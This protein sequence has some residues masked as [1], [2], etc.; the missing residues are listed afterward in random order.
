MPDARQKGFKEKVIEFFS[1]EPMWYWTYYRME[2]V[3][4]LGFLLHFAVLKRGE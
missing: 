4:L 1:H 2:V 3:C